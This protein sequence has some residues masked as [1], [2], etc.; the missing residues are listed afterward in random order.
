MVPARA[1]SV[2]VS[3]SA[4]SFLLESKLDTLFLE[5]SDLGLLS[6]ANGEDVVNS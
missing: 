3:E 1:L 6:C 5:Q 2:A 4:L